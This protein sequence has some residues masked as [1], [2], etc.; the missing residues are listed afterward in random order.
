[1]QEGIIKNEHYNMHFEILEEKNCEN[2]KKNRMEGTSSELR[3]LNP[4]GYIGVVD[5]QK[6]IGVDYED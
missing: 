6:V 5:T 3:F 2:I 1:V 4:Y